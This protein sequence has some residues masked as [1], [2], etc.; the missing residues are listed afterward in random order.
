MTYYAFNE[1]HTK[2]QD[3]FS[4]MYKQNDKLSD[5]QFYI[6]KNCLSILSEAWAMGLQ[7]HG[8]GYIRE[9][10]HKLN[11]TVKSWE[12]HKIV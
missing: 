11:D 7:P 10:L 4:M 9:K 6:I 1:S 8:A 5:A 3:L 2:I 12:E